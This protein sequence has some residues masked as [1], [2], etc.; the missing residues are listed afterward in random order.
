MRIAGG[1][2]RR[3]DAPVTSV[4]VDMVGS[5]PYYVFLDSGKLVGFPFTATGDWCRC[6]ACFHQQPF[7]HL[8]PHDMSLQHLAG[9]IH[10]GD[11]IPG[12]LRID[13]DGRAEV[14]MVQ[15]ARAVDTHDT[16]QT[17]FDCA[18]LENI[19]YLFCP[20]VEA[21]SDGIVP[22]PLV[23]TDKD[24]SFESS[25]FLTPGGVG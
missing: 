18:G 1:P 15:A 13:D 2:G 9:I 21:A 5:R 25:H 4:A 17:V 24:M 6:H 20:P 10:G 22:V 12:A 23:E 11:V 14:A 3:R 7:H 16:L 8:S 19:E